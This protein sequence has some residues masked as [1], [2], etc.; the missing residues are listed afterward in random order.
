MPRR[1]FLSMAL[2]A[3]VL[4]TPLAARADAGS[5]PKM[6]AKGAEPASGAWRALAPESCSPLSQTDRAR[7]PAN[8]KPY[9]DAARRCELSAPD[10]QPQ[11]ALISVFTDEYY[12]GRPAD[13]PWEDF[14]KPLLVDRDFRCVGG[15]R[16]LFPSDQP[17]TLTLRHG[18]WRDGVPQEI[19]VQVINPAV[20]GDYALPV[21]RWD[22]AQH[23]YRAAGA[24]TPDDTS[25]PNS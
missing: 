17:R 14:P 19:R 8:W 4:S 11:V 20:G 10:G 22:A 16:E 23:R 18:L 13:A 5:V 1:P 9:V 3:L 2:T 15:L 6:K 12:R 24:K 21:L 7:L 25:C